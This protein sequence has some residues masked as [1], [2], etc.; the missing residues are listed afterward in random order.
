M[1]AQVTAL[2]F[3]GLN[4]AGIALGPTVVALVTDRWFHDD[5]AVGN[6]IALVAALAAPL[7][8]AF[9]CAALGPFRRCVAAS[10]AT[11]AAGV[12]R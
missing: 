12:R 9:L 5:G 8:A 2:Y 3:F 6:S 7:S 1:R 10:V 11:A 4:L